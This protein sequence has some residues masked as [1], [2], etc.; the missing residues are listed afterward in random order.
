MIELA[1][2][3]GVIISL[4]S[5]EAFGLAA[6]GIIIPGYIALQL[7]EP[8]RILGTFVIALST[9]LLIKLIL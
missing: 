9:F 8:D 2:V 3:L 1:I 6:G 7:T 5:I 4:I